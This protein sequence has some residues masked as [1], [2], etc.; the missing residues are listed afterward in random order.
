MAIHFTDDEINKEYERQDTDHKKVALPKY[1]KIESLA[2]EKLQV[3]PNDP[4]ADIALLVLTKGAQAA[5]AE[6]GLVQANQAGTAEQD[7][8]K[9]VFVMEG[10][11][12]KDAINRDDPDFGRRQRVY[13]EQGYAPRLNPTTKVL[14]LYKAP[15]IEASAQDKLYPVLDTDGKKLEWATT[16]QGGKDDERLESIT[17]ANG[18][19]THFR[20]L[21]EPPKSRF[22]RGRR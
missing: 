8:S 11:L 5:F 7:D 15:Q 12:R 21:P 9:Y 1:V 17:D 2:K 4:D 16:L 6:L 22:S 20:L 3:N 18:V 10:T 14:E 13:E 19:V